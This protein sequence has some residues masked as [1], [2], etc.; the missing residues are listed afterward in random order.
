MICTWKWP[1]FGVFRHHFRS[2]MIGETLSKKL[3][4]TQILTSRCLKP[5]NLSPTLRDKIAPM[6]PRPPF[7]KSWIRPWSISQKIFY[8]IW[9]EMPLWNYLTPIATTTCKIT[10]SFQLTLDHVLFFAN[11]R[12][13]SDW[14]KLS[15]NGFKTNNLATSLLARLLRLS[16]G[17]GGVF[18]D[19][20]YLVEHRPISSG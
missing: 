7:Q 19:K 6:V 10:E 1:K 8:I 12:Q 17:L 14:S 3:R 4:Y 18:T 15:K 16:R 13:D 11:S 2:C 5:M 20:K 9:Y